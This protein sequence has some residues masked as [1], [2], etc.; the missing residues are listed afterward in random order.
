M[1]V[2]TMG[3]FEL[4]NGKNNFRMYKSNEAIN[5]NYTTLP[6]GLV[7]KVEHCSHSRVSSKQVLLHGCLCT[8]I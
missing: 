4:E 1:M 6:K 7:P 2:I 3:K 8:E 5:S